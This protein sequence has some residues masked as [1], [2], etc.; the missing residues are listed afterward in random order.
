MGA[1]TNA[2]VAA[3]APKQGGGIYWA[4]LTTALPTDA[5]TALA[6]AY[7]CLGPMSADGV[8]PSRDTSVEKVKEWDGST[9]A[10]LL[11]DESRAFEFDILGVYDADAL[12]FLFGSANVTTVAP[13]AVAGTKLSIV[14]KGG[15]LPKGVLV[16]EM[17]YGNVKQRKVIPVGEPNVTGENP[18]I[19]G[20]LRGYTVTVEALK[21]SSG[22]FVYEFAEL[23]DAP[24]A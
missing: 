13:T 21:D 12:A 17:K 9:L 23:D 2:R 8:R 14:D 10:S 15:Q 18:Y 24:G 5:S 20:G 1:N 16:L 4:P 3:A 19:P 7:K 6:A 11:S 22:A